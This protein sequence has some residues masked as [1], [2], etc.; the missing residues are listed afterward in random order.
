MLRSPFKALN[1]AQPRLIVF[2]PILKFT[3]RF[4]RRFGPFLTPSVGV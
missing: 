2:H 1:K 4:K 3:T